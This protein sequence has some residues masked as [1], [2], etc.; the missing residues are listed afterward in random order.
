MVFDFAGVMTEFAKIEPGEFFIF[1]DEGR[2]AFAMKIFDASVEQVTSSQKK[3]GVLSFSL[4]V[5]PSMTPPTVLNVERFQ[6]R[7]VCVPRDVVIRPPFDITELRNGSPSEGA[8]G[9]IM[10]A[11][12]GVFIRA[13]PIQ[14]QK[15]IDVDLHTGAAGASFAHP[16]GIWVDAWK[17][18][19]VGRSGETVLC[20]RGKP[21]AS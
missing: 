9:P 15:T 8:P 6:N 5:H 20:E 14:G 21:A 11:S 7:D 10:I 12:D 13:S 19:L 16:G 1:F 2:R 17:I 18:V 4:A 3:M